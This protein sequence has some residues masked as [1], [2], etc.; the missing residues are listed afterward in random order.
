MKIH[1]ISLFNFIVFN[2]LQA[3]AN[4]SKVTAG[5]KSA[6]QFLT[7]IAMIIGPIAFIVSGIIYYKNKME[8]ADKFSGAV[9]GTA[10]IGGSSILY[11]VIYGLFN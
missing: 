1:V 8:G 2:S 5:F 11:S 3:F 9:I 4:T 7:Q 6:Q 10:I